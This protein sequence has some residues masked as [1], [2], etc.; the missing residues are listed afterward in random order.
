MRKI[1][2]IIICVLNFFISRAQIDASGNSLSAFSHN[3]LP[4]SFN[5]NDINPSDIPSLEVLRSMGFSEKQIKEITKYKNGKGK[6][7]VENY[8][9]DTISKKK[10]VSYSEYK[11]NLLNKNLGDSLKDSVF[12]PKEKIFGQALFRKNK[13]S[14]FQNAFDAKAPENYKVGSG[15]EISISIWGYNQFSENLVVDERGYISPSSYGRIYVKGLTFKKMRSLLKS[16]F[17]NF[18]DMKNSEI[19]VTLSYSRV[20]TVNI[21]GEVYYPGSYTL[22]AINTAFNALF[23]AKGPTQI[24]S[25]RNIYI[26]RNGKLVDSLDVYDFMYSSD[27]KHD[28]FL[29]DGDYIFVPPANNIVEVLGEVNRPYTYEAK[30]GEDIEKIIKFSGGFTRNAFTDII[31]LKRKE[32]NNYKVYDVKKE[33]ISDEKI[34]NGDV[35][36]VNKISSVVSNFVS[37]DGSLGVSGDYEFI[38]GERLLDLLIR[39]KCI[40]EKTFLEKVYIIRTNNDNSKSHISIQLDSILNNNNHPDNIFLKEFDI[41][42]VLSIDD[43]VDEFN[44]NISGFV[45]KPGPLKFGKGINL[46]DAITQAGALKEAAIGGKVEISRIL[47]YDELNGELIPTRNIVKSFNITSDFMSSSDVDYKLQPNDYI[48]IRK[49]P[50]YEKIRTVKLDGEVLFPGTYSLLH[51]QE[52]VFELINRAGGLK[53]TA[54]EKNASLIRKSNLKAIVNNK[55]MNIPQSLYDSILVSDPKLMNIIYLEEILE[56]NSRKFID[57][58][59]SKNISFDLSKALSNKKSKHNLVLNNGDQLIINKK[60]DYV[61]LVGDLNGIDNIGISAPYL[62]KRA[63]Y[64]VKNY[65]GGYSSDNKKSNTIVVQ[66]NGAAKKTKNFGLFTISP[67]VYPGSTI[68]VSNDSSLKKK[69]KEIDIDRHIQSVITKVTAIISLTLLIERLNGGY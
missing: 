54:D 23:A 6:Y 13:L 65:G 10:A 44:V 68:K 20:I 64:Y 9:N 12:F 63:H 41:V 28:I 59:Y 42:K 52:T 24:G 38:N 60:L 27:K 39:S 17:S 56:L 14:F 66:S 26:K 19:D 49:N 25:V 67:K 15:D 4:T 45:R 40:S 21:V 47:E 5:P 16:R 62:G 22:P 50:D 33:H 55:N 32:Y 69:K 2:F 31:T 7:N 53:E 34:I 1:T 30:K 57:S 51:K 61:N 43:F 48:F 11:A 46:H 18:F 3:F 36:I 58:S 37:V 29:E 8:N 35:I